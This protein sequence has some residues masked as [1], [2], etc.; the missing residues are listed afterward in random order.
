MKATYDNENSWEGGQWWKLENGFTAIVGYGHCG[1][2]VTKIF[3][4]GLE[5]RDGWQACNGD[6]DAPDW[7]KPWIQPTS[8]GHW[9]TVMRPCFEKCWPE[10]R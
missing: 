4:T 1:E 5:V 8:P 6:D 2:Y 10:S 7:A 3:P 9:Q